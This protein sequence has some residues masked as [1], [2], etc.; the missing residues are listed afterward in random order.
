MNKELTEAIIKHIFAS[1]GVIPSGFINFDRSESLLEKKYLLPVKLNFE[2]TT[3]STGQVWGCQF[4]AEQQEIKVLLGNCSIEDNIKEY[5]LLVQ[6]KNGPI[7]GLFFAGDDSCKF[8]MEPMIACSV[9]GKEWIECST[10]LQASFLT[11]ME[12][13]K[14]VGL[15]WNKIS[16]HEEEFTKLISFID[17]HY[18]V[19]EA[20]YERQK[21]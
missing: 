3:K 7:Y 17:Y 21:D 20:Q 14:E 11:G 5:A 12:Q 8:N 6:L 1:F 19:Y 2:D 10:F 16:S 9:N 13:L 18:L 15:G 4:S